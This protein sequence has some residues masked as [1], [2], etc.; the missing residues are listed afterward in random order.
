[1]QNSAHS[2]WKEMGGLGPAGL[3][4]NRE[5]KL[6][7]NHRAK[8]EGHTLALRHGESQGLETNGGRL[9]PSVEKWEMNFN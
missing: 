3:Q 1:L 5:A 2:F 6:K 4:R 9:F 7:K 8:R